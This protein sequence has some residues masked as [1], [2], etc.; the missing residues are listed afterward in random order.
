M[1][2]SD[3]D[4]D[5]D[6]D[7]LS[8]SQQDDKIAWYENDGS[9]SFGDQQI[10]TTM[11]RGARSV[12]VSDLDGDGDMDVL[13]ASYYDDKIAWYENEGSGS[14]GGQQ[15]ITNSACW[16][17]SVYAVDLEGDGDMDVL[18]ASYS[19]IA[20]YEND[21]W[22]SFD[23]QRI[24]TTIAQGTKSVYA[25][26]LEGDGDMDV[27]S[28]SYW[29]NTIA[30]YENL[31]GNTCTKDIAMIPGVFSLHQNYPNPF[32]PETTIRFNLS[33]KSHVMLRVYDILG[34]Q[35]AILVDRQMN[36]GH[37]KIPFHAENLASGIYFY[38]IETGEYTETKK[39]ILNR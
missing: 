19:S 15:V 29:D 22:G 23:D 8:A 36:I 13:S 5:G 31:M 39:M 7:V 26:D 9:G 10:I 14:F 30:W 18:S 24:I 32:N 17:E 11:A 2:A 38:H 6:M 34:K 3:L 16:A 1:Y 27:L 21:G 33:R 4:G 28:A 37:H 12:Y 35:I 25:C 20:W